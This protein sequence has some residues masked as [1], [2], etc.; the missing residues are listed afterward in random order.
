MEDAMEVHKEFF[1]LPIEDKEKFVNGDTT[2]PM[3]TGLFTGNE[4]SAINI[5]LWRD[6]LLQPCYP[7]DNNIDF[8]P[9]KPLQYRYGNDYFY[10]YLKYIVFIFL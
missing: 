3:K 2:K 7:L 10:Q 5:N 6:V 4:I 9:D 8:W 1:N